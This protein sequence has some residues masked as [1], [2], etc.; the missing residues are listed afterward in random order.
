M[1]LEAV[2]GRKRF[3]VIGDGERQEMILDIGVANTGTAADEAA[4]LE[5]IGRAEP[6]LA[7][8]PAGAD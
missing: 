7:Q 3:S 1:R 4:A 8:Q 2:L 6:V 5:M